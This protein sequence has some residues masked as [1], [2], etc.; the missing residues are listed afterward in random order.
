M[1]GQWV[2]VWTAQLLLLLFVCDLL[3]LPLVAAFISCISCIVC[4][5]QV[6]QWIS[7]RLTAGST[8]STSP[9]PSPGPSTSGDWT[10][11][12]MDRASPLRGSHGK[13]LSPHSRGDSSQSDQTPTRLHKHADMAEQAKHVSIFLEGAAVFFCLSF[14][15]CF[16]KVV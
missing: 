12:Q 3:I 11:T 10:P 2:V 1:I 6:R 16:K 9:A 13:F 5:L 7:G 8:P 15:V 14:S 4:G